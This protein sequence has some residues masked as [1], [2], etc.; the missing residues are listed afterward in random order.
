MGQMVFYQFAW[1][2]VVYGIPEILLKDGAAR[3]IGIFWA[4]ATR[5]VKMNIARA[6]A[7]LYCENT[8]KSAFPFTYFKIKTQ[9]DRHL[10]YRIYLLFDSWYKSLGYS[11]SGVQWMAAVNYVA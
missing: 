11:A 10:V 3:Y 9:C 5:Q 6:R 2:N 1:E 7:Y 8:R 4:H